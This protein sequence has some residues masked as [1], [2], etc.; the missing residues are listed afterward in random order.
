[1]ARKPWIAIG[2]LLVVA[3][4][5]GTHGCRRVTL[6]GDSLLGCARDTFVSAINAN[7]GESWV[8][9]EQIK[10]GCT[11]YNNPI[12][13]VIYSKGMEAAFNR[14]DVVVLSF[15]TNDMNQVAH[16]NI[17]ME[18]AI[19]SLQT[20]VNQA[21]VA[22]AT[23]VVMLESSHQY[24][25]DTPLGARFKMHMDEWF[26]YWHRR[27]GPNEYL[28]LRYQL[29]IADISDEIEGNMD[30]YLSDY[31]HFNSDGARLAAEALVERI[32]QCP[33][34]RWIFGE[35]TLKPDAEFPDNPYP[36][37]NPEKRE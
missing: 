23:C 4:M 35:E 13:E 29:L 20:L 12:N 7:N 37:A 15:G 30:A 34:G 1:M 33:E 25:A 28:G 21:V 10:G 17:S 5:F 19:Q 27:S 3:V 16:D 26:E 9:E 8:Y 32:N 36:E 6:V 31:I 14:P 18:S 2:T 24:R 11:S 22:G